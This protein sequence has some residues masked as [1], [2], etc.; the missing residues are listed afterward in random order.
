MG[1]DVT[2]YQEQA[3]LAREGLAITGRRTSA[4]ARRFCWHTP[5]SPTSSS[6]G[7]RLLGKGMEKNNAEALARG[8]R[9]SR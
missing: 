6:S 1:F 9:A 4:P 7:C 3:E 5:R 2:E 8:R